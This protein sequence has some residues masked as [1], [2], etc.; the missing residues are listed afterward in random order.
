M[1]QESLEAWENV[2]NAVKEL[3]LDILVKKVTDIKVAESYG[4]QKLPAIIFNVKP[5]KLG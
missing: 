1:T 5:Q 3:G 4:A 2:N